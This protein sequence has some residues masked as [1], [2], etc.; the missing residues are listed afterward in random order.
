MRAKIISG[1]V[2]AL[3]LIPVGA[4]A[5]QHDVDVDDLCYVDPTAEEC[6]VEVLP[7][8]PIEKPT[9]QPTEREVE[10]TER[11][12][13]PTDVLAKVETATLARTGIET[14]VFLALALGLLAAGSM[15]VFGAGRRRGSASGS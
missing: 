1:V 9:E 6:V 2:A 3:L 5:D 12:V 14:P 15:L 4:G 8:K 11:E 7:A 13:E 10:P